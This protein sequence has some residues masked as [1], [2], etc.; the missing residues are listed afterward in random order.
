MRP[1]DG[2][3]GMEIAFGAALVLVC[4]WAVPQDPDGEGSHV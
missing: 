2:W 1:E 4:G 3:T